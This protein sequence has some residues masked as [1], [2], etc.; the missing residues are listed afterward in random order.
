MKK[1][2]SQLNPMIPFKMNRW[3]PRRLSKSKRRYNRKLSRVRVV[4]E[5]TISRLKKFW[6][7]N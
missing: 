4:V 6:I 2:F 1:D 7:L 3:H 5:H